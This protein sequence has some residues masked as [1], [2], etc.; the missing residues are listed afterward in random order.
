MSSGA[1]R[2]W[3]GGLEAN[4]GPGAVRLGPAKGRVSTEIVRGPDRE[5]LETL[6]RIE[7]PFEDSQKTTK[8]FEVSGDGGVEC[9]LNLMIAR[10]V[11]GIHSVHSISP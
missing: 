9:L 8:R 3:L 4:A 6:P 5:L 10:D 1:R 7:G 11:D 2:P